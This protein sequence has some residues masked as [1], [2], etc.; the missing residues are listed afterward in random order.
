VVNG[1]SS[2]ISIENSIV[3]GN[4]GGFL[5][6]EGSSSSIQYSL[7]QGLGANAV[8]HNM[9]G[10]LNPKFAD[11]AMELYHLLPSS[12]C[13]NSGNNSA[14]SSGFVQDIEGKVRIFDQQIE[15]GAYEYTAESAPLADLG[16]DTT[17]CSGTRLVLVAP[18][19][20]EA[21]YLWN[22]G[23]TSRMISIDIATT[24]QYYVT[25]ANTLGTSS[26]TIQIIAEPS[27]IVQLGNDT[28]I[29]PGSLLT[30]NAGNRGSTYLWNTGETTQTIAVSSSGTYTV[31]VTNTNGCTDSDSIAVNF[32]VG[33]HDRQ[34][35]NHSWQVYPNPFK[36]QITVTV[37][38]KAMIGSTLTLMDLPGRILMET[39]VTQ[40]IQAIRMSDL[41]AG[42]YLLRSGN[43][44]VFKIEKY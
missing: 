14:I 3:W 18:Y 11:T 43:G 9:D 39:T 24:Q 5:D 17:I 7:V 30:L 12:P 22:T 41:P 28:V 23:A 16:N 33:I 35:T 6:K 36:E 25:I 34:Q 42:I 19:A 26:D 20:A 29:A 32:A 4:N 8:H 40:E 15:L 13:I 10:L 31:M 21:T 37:A 38:D 44:D 1:D 2:T 27:P